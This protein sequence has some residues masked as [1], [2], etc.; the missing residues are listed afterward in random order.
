MRSFNKFWQRNAPLWMTSKLPS[1][2]ICPIP[3]LG[4]FW[5][6]RSL[7]DISFKQQETACLFAC[8]SVYIKWIFYSRII[9]LDILGFVIHKLKN[10]TITKTLCVNSIFSSVCKKNNNIQ[11]FSLVYFYKDVARLRQAS[12][13][14]MKHNIL[15]R[16]FSSYISFQ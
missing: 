13:E 14:E 12:I 8:L 4:E 10:D 9:I 11:S 1:I 3:V 2:N 5:S 6:Q 16:C 15:T 7:K